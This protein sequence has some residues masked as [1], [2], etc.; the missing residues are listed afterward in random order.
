MTFQQ[1]ATSFG[2]DDRIRA[3]TVHAQAVRAIKG[4]SDPGL[5][6]RDR[7]V[8]VEERARL[9]PRSE[10]TLRRITTVEE[11]LAEY[12]DTGGHGLGAQLT[13]SHREHRDPVCDGEIDDDL[14]R[15][16][17]IDSRVVERAVRLEVRHLAA[18][19]VG[20]RGQILELSG[21]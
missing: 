13:E 18:R 11:G 1:G 17:I 4:P 20:R 10:S 21:E 7:R 8:S 9:A 16:W 2:D 15:Y 6:S 14:C 3:V 5:Q 12:R 19:R